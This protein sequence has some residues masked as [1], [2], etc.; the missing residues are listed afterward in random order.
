M[1]RSNFWFLFGALLLGGGS[2]HAEQQ[3]PSG[4]DAVPERCRSMSL[5]ALRFRRSEHKR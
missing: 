4:L 5:I 3:L 2:L 1:R